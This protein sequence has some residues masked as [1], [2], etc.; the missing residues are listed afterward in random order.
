MK[1]LSK[2]K[3]AQIMSE[4]IYKN[5]RGGY[6]RSYE[7]LKSGRIWDTHMSTWEELAMYLFSQGAFGHMSTQVERHIDF[8]AVGEFE[9]E[10]QG[11]VWYNGGWFHG[12]YT[13]VGPT[14]IGEIYEI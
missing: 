3:L 12:L 14:I 1:E 5:Q 9:L 4:V 11:R 13:K 6:T 7:A 8:K 2:R 10:G